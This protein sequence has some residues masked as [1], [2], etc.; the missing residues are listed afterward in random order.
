MSEN[1]QEVISAINACVDEA[2]IHVDDGTSKARVC[3]V[4]DHLLTKKQT[5]GITPAAL[6]QASQ[7]LSAD[8]FAD[9]KNKELIDS[10]AYSGQG[11]APWMDRMLLSPRA[12]YIKPTGRGSRAAFTACCE[13]KDSLSSKKMPVYAIANKYTFGGRL[14]DALEEL[15]DVEW[16][17]LTPIKE[18]G[19]T[20]TYQGG[21][22][23]KLKG[24]LSFFKVNV[25]KIVW[26]VLQLEALG[27][28][29][30]VVVLLTGQMTTQQIAKAKE[31][32]TVHV[33]NVIAAIEWL[34][35]NNCHCWK[36]VD[37]E[38]I[39]EKLRNMEPLIIDESTPVK[40]SNDKPGNNIEDTVSFAAYFP[41]GS[42]K[43]VFGGQASIQDFKSL[44]ERAHCNMA[45]ISFQCDLIRER[46]QDY[47]DDNFARACLQQMP[48]GLGGMEEARYD[49]K[50]KLTNSI[51]LKDYVQHLSKISMPRFHHPLFVLLLQSICQRQTMVQMSS[52]RL[53]GKHT[54]E[55]IANSLCSDDVANHARARQQGHYS[56][57]K[58][59]RQLFD[60]VDAVTRSLPHTDGAATRA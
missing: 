57:T 29:G 7:L 16:A 41:D 38:K 55:S 47:Q 51:N 36:N 21:K 1:T 52:F 19:F 3:I 27:L 15:T 56:G 26:A 50:G 39:R 25:E 53:R 31:I 8:G 23:K 11:K 9:I 28:N 2:V 34:R 35:D 49:S 17:L 46:I 54:H 24:V 58:A 14:P 48:Y 60:S 37:I 18:Y 20:F 44:V 42:M 33:D 43:L 32:S 22:Q 5:T 30:H 12:Q 10:Y 40:G 45:D 6:E 59:S 13:C 4:C